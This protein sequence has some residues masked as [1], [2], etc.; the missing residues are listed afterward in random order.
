V[1]RLYG[2]SV[3]VY[4]DRIKIREWYGGAKSFP[5]SS[6]VEL[7]CLEKVELPYGRSMVIPFSCKWCCLL[8]VGRHSTCILL[9]DEAETAAQADELL[10]ML[11]RS[12]SNRKS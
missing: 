6:P 5:I 10:S 3:F 11:N 1:A 7:R 12:I 2:T 8:R 4:G 9:S